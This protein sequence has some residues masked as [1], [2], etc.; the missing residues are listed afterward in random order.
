MAFQVRPLVRMGMF[1]EAKVERH[2]EDCTIAL[3]DFG[4]Y[5]LSSKDPLSQLNAIN[6]C[7]PKANRD[8][9]GW[10]IRF[11]RFSTI[12]P[13]GKVM[14]RE[15]A[16]RNWYVARIVVD[17]KD[18]SLWAY[19]D[20]VWGLAKAPNEEESEYV[21]IEAAKRRR[22]DEQSDDDDEPSVTNAISFDSAEQMKD[23]TGV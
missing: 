8:N 20:E 19:A 12:N 10:L 9:F 17:P 1:P 13:Y 2:H 5:Q 3:G 22:P 18:A 21:P 11:K 15:R 14:T 6:R 23:I 16:R 7:R 4:H